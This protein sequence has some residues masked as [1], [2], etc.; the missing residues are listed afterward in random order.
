MFS[1]TS[2]CLCWCSCSCCWN[3]RNGYVCLQQIEMNPTKTGDESF[4]GF[5][6]QS[7]SL[8]INPSAHLLATCLLHCSG[9]EIQELGG[10]NCLL[11]CELGMVLY[12]FFPFRHGKRTAWG[13][14]YCFTWHVRPVLSGERWPGTL[15]DCLNFKQLKHMVFFFQ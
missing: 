9:G 14:A 4:W 15:E 8:A 7:C 12:V 10:E 1:F 2:P 6:T 3:P 5:W 13:C 11:L